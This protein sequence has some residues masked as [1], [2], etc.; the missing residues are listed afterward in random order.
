MPPE[1]D[2]YAILQVSPKADPAIV[3]AA[4][5]AQLKAMG[6][7]PDFGGEHDEAAVLNEAYEI[8]G[9]PER[10]RE[11]DKKYLMGL[12]SMASA[13][14]P[15]PFVPS[16]DLRVTPRAVFLNRFRFRKKKGEWMPAHFRDISMGGA[17]FRSLAGF[18][19][20]DTLELDVSDSPVFKP[21][22]KV[23]WVRLIPQRFGL[24]IYEGGFSFKKADRQTLETYL[25]LVGLGHLI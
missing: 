8:L 14:E 15:N 7:H 5:Y 3:K 1:K 20:G 11:Y 2:Y 9:D 21:L 22:G 13:P 16:S 10:R 19:A 23:K 24:P 25:R 4:Y 17:C 18:K 12:V 6:K